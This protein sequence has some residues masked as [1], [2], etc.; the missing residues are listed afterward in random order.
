M[1]EEPGEYLPVDSIFTLLGNIWEDDYPVIFYDVGACNLQETHNFIR[2]Y[3]N[4]TVYAFDPD[5]RNILSAYN[6]G[7]CKTKNIHF[8]PYAVSDEEGLTEFYLSDLES[9]S[10]ELKGALPHGWSASSS[11]LAPGKSLDKFKGLYFKDKCIVHTMPLDIFTLG[12]KISHIDVLWMD[13][14]GAEDKVFKGAQET[15]KRTKFLF[16]EACSDEQQYVGQTRRS[17][18]IDTLTQAGFEVM[19]E[20]PDDILFINTNYEGE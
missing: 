12:H 14:Q 15:L 2:M 5:P 8:Y 9:M 4:A 19:K 6:E 17:T 16:T 13:V 3:P 10:D 11:L 1:S 7:I 20:Y 18:I